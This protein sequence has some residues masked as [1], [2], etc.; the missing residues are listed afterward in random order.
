MHMFGNRTELRV[1]LYYSLLIAR[2]KVHAH[3]T[4]SM[5]MPTAGT[6]QHWK[7]LNNYKQEKT[8]AIVCNGHNW[9]RNMAT[10][11][12]AVIQKKYFIVQKWSQK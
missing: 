9:K 1:F 6:R 12:K 4:I 10:C 11:K 2:A 5:Q 8:S 3:K 7:S